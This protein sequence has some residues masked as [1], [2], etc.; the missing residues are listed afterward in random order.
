MF[1]INT[2]VLI[3]SHFN[4]YK[5]IL[6]NLFTYIPK[7]RNLDYYRKKTKQKTIVI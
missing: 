2:T 3:I 4:D 6:A 7:F 5:L 1:Q